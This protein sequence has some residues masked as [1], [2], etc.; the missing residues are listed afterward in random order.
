VGLTSVVDVD[1]F[2]T[3]R[4]GTLERPGVSYGVLG[5]EVID[6]FAMHSMGIVVAR[7]IPQHS[8]VSHNSVKATGL[9]GHF[10]VSRVG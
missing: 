8:L 5:V 7:P 4:D 2:A 6:Q 3:D 9:G 10:H 1:A